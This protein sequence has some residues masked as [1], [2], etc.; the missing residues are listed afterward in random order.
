MRYIVS[1]I[2]GCYEEYRALLEKIRFSDGDQLYVLGDAMDRGP[3]PV[4]V[5]RDIMSR[6]NVRYI[7][8]NHDAG[9][10]SLIR[11]LAGETAE[12]SLRRCRQWIEDGGRVTLRQFLR[13]SL[14]EQAELLAY[15]ENAAPYERLEHEGRLYVLV[16]AG[17]KGFSPE[18]EP[19]E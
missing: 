11:T 8:G 19:E 1:D 15:L 10:L 3:E 2:H 16:H 17:I 5:L 12:E 18:K 14:Q 9:F 7:L 13:L 4:K 6:S